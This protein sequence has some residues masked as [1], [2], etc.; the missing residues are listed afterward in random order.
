[1]IIRL[2][3]IA[4]AMTASAQFARAMDVEHTDIDPVFKGQGVG[5]FLVKRA[6]DDMRGKGARIVPLCPFVAGW[7]RRHRQYED[8]VDAKTLRRYKLANKVDL[9][10]R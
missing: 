8:L 2:L 5:S 6:L 7:I 1:M 3:L 4:L 9:R 10:S